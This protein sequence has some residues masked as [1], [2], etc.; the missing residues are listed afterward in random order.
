MSLRSFI[1][2]ENASHKVVVWSKAYCPYCTHTKKL[3]TSLN[4]DDV[5][6]HELDQRKDGD[7]IQ[8][9]LAKMTGQ[10]TVPNVFVMNTHIGGNDDSQKANRT[11]KLKELLGI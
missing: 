2:Q 1:E 3:F 4:V 10:R 9:E 6:V 11:G 5:V 8:S 7:A